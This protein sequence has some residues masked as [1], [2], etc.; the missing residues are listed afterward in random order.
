VAAGLNQ[1]KQLILIFS[2][3][4]FTI[5]LQ[6]ILA[7]P[8]PGPSFRSSSL[9][10]QGRPNRPFFHLIRNRPAK[11]NFL[12]PENCPFAGPDGLFFSK[13]LNNLKGFAYFVP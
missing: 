4:A 2:L 12:L 3:P 1:Q 13:D 9:K 11:G 7:R 5:R 10:G 8:L 6:A